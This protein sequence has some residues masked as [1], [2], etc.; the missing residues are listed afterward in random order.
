MKKIK[1]HVTHSDNATLR[2]KVEAYQRQAQLSR[3]TPHAFAGKESSSLALIIPFAA[4]ALTPFA[5]MAQ[6]CPGAGTNNTVTGSS[7]GRFDVYLDLDN[8]GV[9]DFRLQDEPD[10]LFGWPL[11]TTQVS[12]T[13]AGGYWYA[14]RH[15]GTITTAANFRGRGQLTP[16]STGNYTTME[17]GGGTNDQWAGAG[18]ITGC[19][20]VRKGTRIGFIQVT[21]NNTNSTNPAI[22][23]ITLGSYGLAAAGVA[24]VSCASCT[25]LPVEMRSFRGEVQQKRAVLRWETETET[26]NRGFEVEKSTDGAD[27]FKIGW[28]EGQGNSSRLIAYTFEDKSFQENQVNY[29]RLKQ[30]N[31]DGSSEYTKV[32]ML[33]SDNGGLKIH[34]FA[35]NPAAQGF[36]YLKFDAMTEGD[37][38]ITLFDVSGRVAKEVKTSYI[39]GSNGIRLDLVGLTGGMYYAKVQSGK[40][41]GYKPLHVR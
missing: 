27:F 31:Q 20:G 24:S 16:G 21:Y 32:I 14:V 40:F 19:L 22:N 8:D 7:A 39:A 36:T 3:L 4:A 26:N 29:Y 33:V 28:V 12:V 10:D 38:T 41:T 15:T 18:N 23:G 17:Y 37:V 13:Q 30:V 9:N 34:D 11:G 1:K 35:P 25:T 5:A 2:Q 6:S